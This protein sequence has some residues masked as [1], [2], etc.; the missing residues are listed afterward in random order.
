M[1]KKFIEPEITVSLCL[2]DILLVSGY[3][4]DNVEGWKWGDTIGGNER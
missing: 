3:G 4:Q 1:K 2:N